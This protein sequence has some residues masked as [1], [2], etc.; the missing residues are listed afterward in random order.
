MG[1]DDMNP[2][3]V[4]N[5]KNIPRYL[6]D[7]IKVTEKANLKRYRDFRRTLIGGRISGAVLSA[8]ALGIYFYTMYAVKQETFL[9]DFDEPELEYIDNPSSN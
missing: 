4:H 8:T 3:D 1:K 9:D 2:V 7:Q 5:D 6:L